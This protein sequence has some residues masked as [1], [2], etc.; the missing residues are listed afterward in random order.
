[1]EN[2]EAAIRLVAK[3]KIAHRLVELG[4][5]VTKRLEELNL[6]NLV[7]NEDTVKGLKTLRAD[8]NKELE[9]YEE[10]RKFVKSGVLDPYME[11]ETLYKSEIAEKY[12]TAI[13][14]LKDKIAQ[15]E[16]RIKTEKRDRVKA[17]FGELCTAEKLDFLQFENVGLDINLSTSE[18]TYKDKCNEFVSKTLDDLALIA[19]SDYQAETLA[20]YKNTLNISHAI[21]TVRT[22]KEQEKIEAERIRQ[23]EITRR[24]REV[25]ASGMIYD[26]FGKVYVYNDEIFIIEKTLQE[27]TKE[28]FTRKLVECQEKIR[29]AKA[30]EKPA[31]QAEI[32]FQAPTAA[33]E[34]VS[35]PTVRKTTEDMVTASF[36]V[37][38]TM[39][40]LRALGQY[41]RENGITYQNI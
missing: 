28:D 19:T 40:Q 31:E 10:Q 38:G 6:P 11:F 9:T 17:Y 35:A 16:T 5:S 27:S 7:A 39:A 15:V 2:N 23:A 1:M 24:V 36:K 29:E 41:M 30:A 25:I 14:A 4:A 8:L 22:R 12:K 26:D 33:Q 34:A 21:T 37:T 32:S 18:K 20:E 13:D 3:P